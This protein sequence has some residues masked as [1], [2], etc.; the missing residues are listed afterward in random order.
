[1]SE[2]ARFVGRT[3]EL[4]RLESAAATLHEGRG[5]FVVITGEPGIG[6]TA[7]ASSFAERVRC[8]GV[9]VLWGRAWEWGG[10]PPFWPWRQVVRG[11]DGAPNRESLSGPDAF[12]GPES[13]SA[14]DIGFAD[15][16]CE[17]GRFAVF[18]NVTERLRRAA[19]GD[20]LAVILEDLH[21]ADVASLL[22]LRFMV[23]QLRDAA[24]LLIATWRTV[25]SCAPAEVTA[26]M[27]EMS[28]VAHSIDLS[29]LETE[30][31]A[32]L[33]RKGDAPC[34]LAA[35]ATLH[36]RTGGNPLLLNALLESGS[37][38]EA[39]GVLPRRVSAGVER[40][41]ARLPAPARAVLS[42]ASVV[43]CGVG[44]PFLVKVCERPLD[45]VLE[46][47]RGLHAE[48]ILVEKPGVS[49]DYEFCHGLFR[50]VVYAALAPGER[51]KLHRAAGLALEELYA[52]DPEAHLAE[53]A[54]HFLAVAPDAERGVM[55]ATRAGEHALRS[56]AYEDA[57]LHFTRGI[58]AL[59]SLSANSAELAAL[60]LKL[61][62]A[63]AAAGLTAAARETYARARH[64]ARDAGASELSAEIAIG[65]AKIA[66]FG[67]AND[68]SVE[69]L[70]QSLATIRA[71]AL[72]VRL[73]GALMSLIW[74]R[75]NYVAG[76]E[77]E[78]LAL[79]EGSADPRLRAE[80]LAAGLVL[81]WVPER[82]RFVEQH[83]RATELY[84]IAQNLD[85]DELRLEACRGYFMTSMIAGDIE[86]AKLVL[87]AYERLAERLARPQ[88][89]F[90]VLL[91]RIMFAFMEGHFAEAERLLPLA[92]R[93]GQRAG[94]PQADYLVPGLLHQRDRAFNDHA[95][96]TE[97]LE[98]F[99]A[100]VGND[101]PPVMRAA[102][103]ARTYAQLGRCEEARRRLDTYFDLAARVTWAGGPMAVSSAA[104]A[105]WH[106]GDAERARVLLPL[107][108]PCE[109]LVLM[110]GAVEFM[111]TGT[112]CLGLAEASAGEH[113]MARQ[114]LEKA[115]VELDRL[116][117]RPYAAQARS[118][119]AVL[120]VSSDPTRAQELRNDAAVLA[121]AVGGIWLPLAGA[122]ERR[123][124]SA[125][126]EGTFVAEGD[127]YTIRL[128]GEVARIRRSK[129]LLFI[130]HLLK[131]EGTEVHVLELTGAA[132][133]DGQHAP[134]LDERAKAAYRL[135]RAALQTEL[136]EAE[137]FADSARAL[138]VREELEALQAELCRATGLGGRNRT[139]G[140]AE[141]ARA[142]V[143]LAIRRAIRGLEATNP[144][145]AAHFV[146]AIATG[147]FCSYRPEPRA[148]VA[149]QFATAAE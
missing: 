43:G 94:D 68:E 2:G 145:L 48:G 17:D 120:L 51:L 76:L 54:R 122:A 58:A 147:T 44:A 81:S 16:N 35:A 26:A 8:R 142:R 41:I 115:I 133:V 131:S 70:E 74:T 21:A 22:L 62:D 31:I 63:Q 128:G 83:A 69:W 146:S 130:E 77:R 6:K 37:A 33:M 53:L 84:T 55:Y 75:L 107:L 80:A 126:S 123:D 46:Q 143:T 113:E 57:A 52:S 25:D 87:D 60:C 144:S 106:L 132:V 138:R 78:L 91:R 118:A 117:A 85:D 14:L 23:E 34:S 42:A 4:A 88:L 95:G 111:G 104:W 136:S 79:A 100:R 135:R 108:A 20:A 121:E 39:D 9:R 139:N 56:F 109:G 50:E 38:F 119:L 66:G 27:A 12:E 10:A 1:V 59:E 86:Q 30:D 97:T 3:V 49:A 24:V 72:R 19:E 99:Q 18:D 73:I 65:R 11:L 47:L 105:V 137:Q 102:I 71:P 114:H 28:R 40:R 7:L 64:A 98:R 5:A 149:W 45:D 89:R 101:V 116:G 32:E 67:R 127:Y 92:E 82:A 129:G 110:G 36:D 148:R 61:A 13:V 134:L 96:L 112:L 103:A 15:V 90:N 140:V 141:R 29:G 93:A 125:P 124:R